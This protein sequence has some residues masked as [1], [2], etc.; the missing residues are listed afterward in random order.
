MVADPQNLIRDATELYLSLRDIARL[1]G[2][3]PQTVADW[4]RG[5]YAPSSPRTEQA[6]A[7]VR[8]LID[9]ADEATRLRWR[10]GKARRAWVRENLE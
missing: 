4:E 5:V 9:E 10:N 6:V 7:R 2:V 3:S 8:R 1:C